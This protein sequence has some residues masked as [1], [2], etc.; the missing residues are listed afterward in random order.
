MH[1]SSLLAPTA[2]AALVT[3]LAGASRT[4][5][6]DPVEAPDPDRSTRRLDVGLGGAV[7]ARSP[8]SVSEAGGFASLARPLWLGGAGRAGQL[9]ARV[10]GVVGVGERPTVYTMAGVSFGGTLLLVRR[11]GFR[12]FVGPTAGVQ[13]GGDGVVPSFGML[14]TGGYVL[15]PFDDPR[16]QITLDLQMSFGFA[17]RSDP[18]NDAPLGGVIGIGLGYQT[19]Y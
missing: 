5:H 15:R 6:A 18:G 10:T 7:F 13:W 17:L 11:F 3:M 1:P 4:A 19:P 9:E 8:G 16:R 12:L 2:V 14:G